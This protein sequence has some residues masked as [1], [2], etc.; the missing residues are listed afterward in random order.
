M[1]SLPDTLARNREAWWWPASGVSG[2]GKTTAVV[3]LILQEVARGNTVLATAGSNKAVDNICERILQSRTKGVVRVGNIEKIDTKATPVLWL[4][5]SKEEAEI[6]HHSRMGEI[7]NHFDI[8]VVPEE[9]GTAKS[10]DLSGHTFSI[11][12]WIMLAGKEG[13]L[14]L[15]TCVALAGPQVSSGQSAAGEW[16]PKQMPDG[17]G[18]NQSADRRHQGLH[19][20]LIPAAMTTPSPF[21]E[22]GKPCKALISSNILSSMFWRLEL[23]AQVSEERRLLL[24]KRKALK[25]AVWDLKDK[26]TSKILRDAVVSDLSMW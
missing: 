23:T 6:D 4:R 12:A 25:S 19:Q 7:S 3:E 9:S 1:P 26:E 5:T 11:P 10:H 2:T 13:M 22:S 18:Q 20:D 15:L 8:E 14:D 24:A 17:S 16:H 21:L